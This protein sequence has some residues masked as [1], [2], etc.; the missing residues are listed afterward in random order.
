M[1]SRASVYVQLRGHVGVRV[2]RECLCVCTHLCVWSYM[3]L[4]AFSE[5]GLVKVWG[6]AFRWDGGQGMNLNVN[7]M[8]DI[9]RKTNDGGRLWLGLRSSPPTGNKV[10]E[11]CEYGGAFLRRR[12]RRRSGRHCTKAFRRKPTQTQRKEP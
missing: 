2:P 10:P 4:H 3:C 8:F 6:C 1:C 7:R 11:C 12:R 9:E 5:S